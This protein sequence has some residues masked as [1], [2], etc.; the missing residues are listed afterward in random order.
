MIAPIKKKKLSSL[1][2]TII[3]IFIIYN[4]NANVLSPDYSL[5]INNNLRQLTTNTSKSEQTV[6]GSKMKNFQLKWM[7]LKHLI[8]QTY[9][10]TWEIESNNTY[11]NFTNN[12]GTI[13]IVFNY[14]KRTHIQG[15]FYYDYDLALFDGEDNRQS[16]I[17]SNSY[18]FTIAKENPVIEY[19]NT[20]NILSINDQFQSSIS[21]Y[22]YLALISH[23]IIDDN[24]TMGYHSN[25]TW[26]NLNKELN[27]IISIKDLNI[28]FN[29]KQIM[30]SFYQSVST[31]S[32]WLSILGMIQA[33]YFNYQ[34]KLF[35]NFPDEAFKVIAIIYNN[36]LLIVFSLYICT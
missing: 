10:G 14:L 25:K 3:F 11:T 9:V 26:Y 4:V 31:F 2:S 8:S 16:I 20:T 19:D 35:N 6:D 13:Q 23:D 29:A 27:G 7:V 32:S 30:P 1:L 17:I 15:T 34:L 36:Y 33:F 18:F 21:Q 5:G 28:V 12:K 24:I 22:K